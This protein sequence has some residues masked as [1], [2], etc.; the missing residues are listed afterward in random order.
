MNSG[1][2]WRLGT[3]ERNR[4]TLFIL[5]LVEFA[6]AFSQQ[7]PSDSSPQPPAHS[8]PSSAQLEVQLQKTSARIGSIT[9]VNNN[10][11]ATDTPEENNAL[12]R[13]ANKLHVVSRPS[14]L[15]KQLLFKE[16][17]VYVERLLRESERILRSNRYLFDAEIVPVAL[18]DGIVDLEVRTRDVWTFKPGIQYGRSGG[19]NS[20]GFELQESNLFGLGKEITVAQKTDVDRTTNEFRYFDPQIFGSHARMELSHSTNTDGRRRNAYFDLPFYALDTRWSA[21][22]S[23]LD[24][25]RTDQRYSL[26]KVADEFQHQQE[27]LQLLGGTSSGLQNGWVRRFTYGA[28]YTEDY[29]APTTT[30]LSAA[31]LPANRQFAYPFVGFIVFDDQFEKRRNEDQIERTEDLFTGK[32]LQASIGWAGEHFGSS[33]NAAILALGAGNTMEWRDRRHTLVMQ[34]DAT[35]RI[36]DGAIANGSLNTAARYYWRMARRQLFYASLS[37]SIT[38]S[39][40]ADRQLT[41]GGDSGLRGY[42]LRYQD[43]SAV[44]LLTLEHRI[45]TKYYLFRIFHVGG[46]TFFDAGR[47]WGRG[48]A[49]VASGV[50]ANKGLLKDIGL[51]LRFGSSRSAFGNV[52]HVDLAFPLDGD[53]SIH[54]VQFIVETKSSF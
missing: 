11:F 23:A 44:A 43:G 39:L 25:E 12:F 36:E 41:L 37:A 52:I 14:I 2:R 15:R 51:G 33:A 19:T 4:Y 40:D 21:S 46:A 47:T 13:L 5:L 35:G 18:H 17:D 32:Y 9:I 48:N 29:F 26:G 53:R 42:P 49:P 45:Y 1:R 10:V 28:A 20:T 50:E 34:G 3:G 8:P 6:S 31:V 22:A 27:L 24:W 7:S 16:G 54:R 38:K 30:A